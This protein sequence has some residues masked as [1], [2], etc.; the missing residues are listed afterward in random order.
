[1]NYIEE[2]VVDL[3]DKIS[4][5]VKM[6]NV[7]SA[8]AHGVRPKRYKVKFMAP[9]LTNYP[10][11][12]GN[13]QEMWYLSRQVMDD[14]QKSF[15]GCPVVKEP[16]HNGDSTP[17][18]FAQVAVGVI[19][20]VWTEEDG[21]DWCQVIIWDEDTQ[22]KIDRDGWNVSCAYNTLDY[23]AGGV[24]NAINYDH[25][26]TK[27]EYI[28]LAIVPAP[29]QT[30]AQI[31]LNSIDSANDGAILFEIDMKNYKLFPKG[32]AMLNWGKDEEPVVKEAL[33]ILKESGVPAD[34]MLVEQFVSEVFDEDKDPKSI[35]KRIAKSYSFDGKKYKLNFDVRAYL[36]AAIHNKTPMTKIVADLKE[37][38]L[39][40]SQA[41]DEIN[42]LHKEMFKKNEGGE[43]M[44]K[45]KAALN[46]VLEK[47]GLAPDKIKT[48]VN[49]MEDEME[50][51]MAIDPEKATIETPDGVVPLK[52]MISAYEADAEAKKNAKKSEDKRVLTM[53]DEYEGVPVKAMY[54]A[55][56]KKNEAE[57]EAKKN[58]E[59]EKKKK[60]EEEKL[61]KK[62]SDRRAALKSEGKTDEEIEKTMKDEADAEAES[63]KNE[64]RKAALKSEGKTDEEIKKIIADEASKKNF[65]ALN[66]ARDGFKG[67]INT[68]K[69][70]VSKSTRVAANKKSKE[71]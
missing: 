58:A 3:A 71:Y 32:K 7:V 2:K 50:N 68:P 40:E 39:S 9:G 61:A 45:I 56:K 53:D 1:M 22:R 70:F 35:A 46:A 24:L 48:V 47:V 33:R 54:E 41:Q 15:V 65:N 36:E 60:D 38:G 4:F 62:N 11:E 66:S 26:V 63:K 13:D 64:S 34:K 59:D 52:D 25:E 10:G 5:G 12:T 19:S 67:E 16:D 17:D 37:K 14:M 57:A 49:E 21:W 43:K 51:E 69:A 29:R 55:F 6:F 31:M 27:A 20:D 23:T 42:K 44:N 28:H 30:G 18:K 8:L